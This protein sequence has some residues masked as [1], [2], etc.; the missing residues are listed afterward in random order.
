MLEDAEV[1]R[2]HDKNIRNDHFIRSA[3]FIIIIIII[4]MP[5]TESFIFHFNFGRNWP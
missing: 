4:I 3:G 2:K 5:R 1:K